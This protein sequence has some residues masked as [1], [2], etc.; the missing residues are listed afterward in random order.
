MTKP[1]RTLRTRLMAG[2][3]KLKKLPLALM[4][5]LPVIANEGATSPVRVTA[6]RKDRKHT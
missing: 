2:V 1:F 5:A 6:R 4:E 3:S